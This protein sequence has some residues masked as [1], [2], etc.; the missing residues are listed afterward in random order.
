MNQRDLFLRHVGQTSG[1]PLSIEIVRAEGCTMWD[2]SGKEYLDLIG[3]ISVCNMGHRHPDV[4]AAAKHQIDAYLHV[5]VYGELIE[6]PQVQYARAITDQLPASLDSVF[7]TNSGTEATEGAMKLAKRF[8]GKPKIVAFEQS[9]HGSTQGA[10]S[11]MGSEYWRNAFRPLLPGIIHL[12]HGDLDALKMIDDETA[13]VIAEPI[14]AERGVVTP[15]IEWMT[16]LRERCS[17]AGALLILDEI[18]TGMGRTGTL[19]AFEKTGIVPDILLVGKAFGA[20]M[21]LGGFIAS[22]EMMSALTHDPVLGH[23]STFGGHPVCCAAGLAGFRALLH[24]TTLQD[25]EKKSLLFKRLL[26]H[27]MI[28][29]VRTAGLLMAIEFDSWDINKRIIDSC[30]EKGLF[31]DWFLFAQN[32]M[33]L[34]PPLTISEEQIQYACTTIL[35]VCD[36]MRN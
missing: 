5:M 15:S 1:A 29:E 18:Q 24:S 22:R 34:A 3:G 16:R 2:A 35:K 26:H 33:R 21:P 12:T 11:V 8:T 28:K 25:V 20:G 23:I 17:A 30:I 36:N 31:T 19:F 6:S 13:C 27:P 10:L 32:C 14:Q 7:Y 9:Y 4:V